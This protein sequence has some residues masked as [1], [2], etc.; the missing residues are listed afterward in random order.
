VG[1]IKSVSGV[2]GVVGQDLN[3]QVA[4][5]VAA[6]FGSWLGQ[7]K[8]IVGR[9]SRL[10]GQSLQAAAMAGLTGVGCNVVDVDIVSTPGGALMIGQH[11][12]QGGVIITASHNPII[13]NGLKLLTAEGWAP[14]PEQIRQI[15]DRFDAQQFAWKDVHQVGRIQIDGGTARRHVAAVVERLDVE[16][17]RRKGF[18]VVLDSINGGG[19]VEGR[20][21]LEELGCQVIHLNGEPTGKFAHPPEPTADNLTSLCEAVSQNGAAIGFAQDPDA[22]RLAIV[23]ERG[24]YIGEEFTLVLAAWRML[25]RHPGPVAANLSTSRMIDDVAQ[26]F[27]QTVVRTPVGE[28]NVGVGMRDN[29]CVLGGEGNGGVIWPDIVQVRDSLAGMGLVLELL[30]TAGQSLSTLAGQVPRYCIAKRKFPADRDKAAAAVEAVKKAFAKER[31]NTSDGVRVD[32]ADGWVQL[33]A[34][35]TE[36]IMRL[37]A[38]APDEG[39]L[40]RLLESV[41]DAAGLSQA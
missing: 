24:Q 39:S 6:A 33:R 2:R 37:I 25:E 35:N 10:S 11:Q 13:W 21:L 17:I 3:P 7:G 4:M 29:N 40:D 30:A 28:A 18:R 26:R 41:A 38:E 1:L 12:A 20:L 34:S 27:G 23:D 19:C 9:D 32:F 15:Y 36:P 22:D 16:A 31:L 8:L 14:P 5:Q